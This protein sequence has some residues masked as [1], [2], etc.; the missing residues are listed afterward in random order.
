[1]SLAFFFGSVVVLGPVLVS[2]DGFWTRGLI[3]QTS[4][5]FFYSFW[6]RIARRHAKMPKRCKM[7]NAP[8][9]SKIVHL[10]A[11]QQLCRSSL[12]ASPTVTTKRLLLAADVFR[13]LDI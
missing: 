11:G 6:S 1:M 3:T 7:Q 4:S 9:I 8:L 12:T 10:E 5:T 13:Y 2:E